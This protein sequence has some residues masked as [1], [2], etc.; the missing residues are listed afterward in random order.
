MIEK[1]ARME[2]FPAL[3]HLYPGGGDK[4]S[5]KPGPHQAE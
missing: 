4:L 5:A 3:G 1:N 2:R